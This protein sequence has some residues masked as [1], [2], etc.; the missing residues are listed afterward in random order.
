MRAKLNKVEGGPFYLF[1]SPRSGTVTG[2]PTVNSNYGNWGSTLNGFLSV[3]HNADGSLKNG[4]YLYLPTA[5][6]AAWITAK[7]A[8][9]S[10]RINVVG[11]GD[12]ITAGQGSSDIMIDSWWARLRAAILAANSNG[13]GGDHYGLLY[14]VVGLSTATPPIAINGVFNTDWVWYNSSFNR[15]AFNLNAR[16]P[17]IS[18]TPPYNVVGFDIL[19]LDF[20]AGTWTYNVDGGS[21]T[22]VT[23]TGAGVLN[24]SIVKKIAIAGL[25][26]GSHTL[27]INSSAS[28]Y[29]CAILG[30]TAYKASTGL[31]FANM[32]MSGMGLVAGLG[33]S[34]NSLVDT[35][36]S[37]AD[38][39]ALYQGYQGTT[40]SPASLTGLGFPA[41]PDLAI[42]AFGVNDAIQSVSKA[43]F[44]NA[45][46][47]LVWS[48]RFGKSDACSIVIV[49]MWCSDGTAASSTAVTNTDFGS[50]GTTAYRDL[51][52]AML[53]VA[54]TNNCAF[55]DVHGLFGRKPVTNVWVTSTSDIHPTPVG[56][57]KIANILSAI[58]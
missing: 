27:N 44:K 1:R 7:A 14:S 53:E 42:I 11:I 22:T 57:L 5:W 12:S 49:A 32:G 20:A 47:R 50:A 9:A 23:T 16:T 33:D 28:S 55:V 26:V 17:Y 13:L 34:T 45:L 31:C 29:S 35:S 52:Q 24:N 30:V 36:L 39:L 51:K 48:L 43:D 56:H 4:N 2:L 8:I 38:R 18:C 46:L 37:P 19:Y 21:N 41:Q 6:D 58:V 40:A 25:T 15:S 3:A 10:Q 54:Q